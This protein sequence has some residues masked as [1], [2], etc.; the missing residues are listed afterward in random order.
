MPYAMACQIEEYGDDKQGIV[1]MVQNINTP[2][3]SKWMD[4]I[5]GI[6]TIHT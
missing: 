4:Q 5:G 2:G 6:F 3:H 1:I